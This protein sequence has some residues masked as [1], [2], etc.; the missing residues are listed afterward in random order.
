[1]V[2]DKRLSIRVPHTA[3]PLAGLLAFGLIQSLVFRS[4]DG[5]SFSISKDVEATRAAA[6]ALFFLLVSFVIAA[7]FFTTYGRL[8]AVALTLTVYG[9]AMAVFALVQHFTW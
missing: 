3:L 9:L 6:L 5:T 2:M 8:R 4:S 7:N 1:V